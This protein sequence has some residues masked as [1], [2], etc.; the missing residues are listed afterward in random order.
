M[1]ILSNKEI[2]LI[3]DIKN[4]PFDVIVWAKECQKLP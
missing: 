2:L 4:L 1:G 3:R